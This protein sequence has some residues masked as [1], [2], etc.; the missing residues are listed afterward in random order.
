[1]DAFFDLDH[2][3]H[4]PQKD[5]LSSL[6]PSALSSMQQGHMQQQASF[7]PSSAGASGSQT[8]DAP[9]S[10]AT[11]LQNQLNMNMFNNMMQIQSAGDSLVGQSSQ[12]A[13]PS[14][15]QFNAQTV[16]EQFKIAQLQQLQ[17]LQNQI[18]Q[19]QVCLR[20]VVPQHDA[21]SKVDDQIALIS[22]QSSFL[23][24]SP[25]RSDVLSNALSMSPVKDS[26]SSQTDAVSPYSGLPTPGA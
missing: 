13:G 22:G 14:N 2:H 4:E 12:G 24:A 11:N 19:Q 6:F 23:P 26:N 1:M 25:S 17:Q 20:Q 3:D 16:F 10:P 5:I 7:H 18:F 9:L 8:S 15:P 21:H